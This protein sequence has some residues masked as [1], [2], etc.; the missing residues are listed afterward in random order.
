M[1]KKGDT[2]ES[3]PFSTA[4]RKPESFMPDFGDDGISIDTISGVASFTLLG[5]LFGLD[6]SPTASKLR[7]GKIEIETR[8]LCL[9][10]SFF[11]QNLHRSNL[12]IFLFFPP[13]QK[14]SKDA[15]QALFI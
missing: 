11:T 6:I 14:T 5:G 9:I 10:S 15:E 8:Y 12:R 2:V 1:D 4:S 7:L 13:L 3:D